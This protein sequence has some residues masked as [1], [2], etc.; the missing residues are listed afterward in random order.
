MSKAR[1]CV[2]LRRILIK[3]PVC[4]SKYLKGDS[5]PGEK[6][7]KSPDQ[8]KRW[9]GNILLWFQYPVSESA[10]VLSSERSV[11]QDIKGIKRCGKPEVTLHVHLQCDGL[12]YLNVVLWNQSNVSSWV[13][14]FNPAPSDILKAQT[15]VESLTITTE[16]RLRAESKKMDRWNYSGL[17]FHRVT[18]N[19]SKVTN[20]PWL[21]ICFQ[22]VFVKET[23]AD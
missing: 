1:V 22:C 6:Q 11:N 9:R 18:C 15:T 8:Q 17:G 2:P 13:L 5:Y 19:I 23:R 12:L 20:G 7:V 4:L 14:C 21:G 16:T 10:S 3:L